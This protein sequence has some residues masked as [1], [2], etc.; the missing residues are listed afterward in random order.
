MYSIK[1]GVTEADMGVN[2]NAIACGPEQAGKPC[3]REFSGYRDCSALARFC[4]GSEV[5]EQYVSVS[6]EY[7]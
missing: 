7:V 5:G 3:A 2:M 6:V 1:V 4:C